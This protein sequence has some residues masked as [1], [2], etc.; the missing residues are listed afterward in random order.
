M[1]IHY[2]SVQFQ[3]V[4]SEHLSGFH[5][6]PSQSNTLIHG[7]ALEIN[8]HGKSSQ[9]AFAECPIGHPGNNGANLLFTERLAV[10]LLPNYFLGQHSVSFQ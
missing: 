9:L 10:A 5:H 1:F 8:R 7:H 3:V 6:I 2:R 4:P